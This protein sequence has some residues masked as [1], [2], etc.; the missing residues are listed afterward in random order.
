MYYVVSVKWYALSRKMI[1]F[2]V[3]ETVAAAGA[4]LVVVTKY[5]PPAETADV[6]ATLAGHPAVYGFGEN[7]VEALAAKQLPREITH[8]IG[9]IQSRKIPQIVHYC[10]TIHS[11]DK[12]SHAGKMNQIARDEN[13]LI[14]LFVQ[15][16]VSGE[17]QKGGIEPAELPEFLKALEPLPGLEVVGLSGMGQ[18][19]ANPEK[20]TQEFF[21]LKSLREQHLP[22]GLISA[23]T[24]SDYQL[25]LETGIDIVRVGRGLWEPEPQDHL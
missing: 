2:K 10:G 5:L 22:S 25:A 16:N 14:K 7:R 18:L 12:L 21:R 20:K 19:T 15:I 6:Q 9:R 4:Q 13:L 1:N 17:P 24:S 11:L 3:L 8:F 23:G